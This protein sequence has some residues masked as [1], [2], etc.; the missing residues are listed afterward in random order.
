LWLQSYDVFGGRGQKQSCSDHLAQHIFCFV[1]EV[2]T[3]EKAMSAHVRSVRHM[4]NVRVEGRAWPA[5]NPKQ[6]RTRF[7]CRQKRNDDKSWKWAR[8]HT[9]GPVVQPPRGTSLYYRKIVKQGHA[10]HEQVCDHFT[11]SLPDRFCHRSTHRKR[12]KYRLFV[13]MGADNTAHRTD[14]LA[15]EPVRGT[16]VFWRERNNS[17]LHLLLVFRC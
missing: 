16:K 14:P 7:R 5:F 3:T 1:A 8:D 13:A 9:R 11:K 6:R 12:R 15:S 4:L 2:G 10:V 17:K